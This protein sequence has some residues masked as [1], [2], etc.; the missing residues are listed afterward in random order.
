M[1]ACQ[2]LF[3]GSFLS[4]QGEPVKI[5]GNQAVVEDAAASYKALAGRLEAYSA[6]YSSMKKGA[7]W[8]A[9]L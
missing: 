8:T 2:F 4:A 7:S 3:A 9:P 1:L 6:E 5:S